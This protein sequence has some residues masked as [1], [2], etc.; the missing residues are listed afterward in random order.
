MDWRNFVLY[1]L[2][3][4]L[5]AVSISLIYEVGNVVSEK[6]VDVIKHPIESVSNTFTAAIEGRGVEK[7]SPADHVAES[8]IKVYKNKIELD[9]QN[10]IWSKFTDTNSMDPLLDAGSNGL[11]IVPENAEQINLGDIVSYESKDGII[12]HRVIEINKDENGTYFILKGDNNPEQDPGKVRF[13]QIKGVV[14]GVI[15]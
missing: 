6:P 5:G 10:A 7:L 13:E 12:V 15:Y 9:I 3:F 11:E 2:I 14:V 8:Q 4:A 1:V